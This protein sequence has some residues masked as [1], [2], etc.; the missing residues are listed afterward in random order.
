MTPTTHY[1]GIVEKAAVK[2]I[3]GYL[4]LSETVRCAEADVATLLSD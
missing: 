3:A 2:S 4:S 1:P